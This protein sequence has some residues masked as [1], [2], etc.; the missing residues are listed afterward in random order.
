M[1]VVVIL[2]GVILVAAYKQ[3]AP[4]RN[5]SGEK[6]LSSSTIN[7]DNQLFDTVLRNMSGGTTATKQSDPCPEGVPA[8]VR[9]IP[10]ADLAG[11]TGS[12]GQAGVAWFGIFMGVPRVVSLFQSD[13][14][15]GC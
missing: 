4:A 8:G 12:E 9:I 10:I 5:P 15:N 6:T 3:A 1:F 2:I 14:R 13:E 7:K 11:I